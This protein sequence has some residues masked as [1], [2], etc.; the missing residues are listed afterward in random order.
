MLHS[1]YNNI[2]LEMVIRKRDI[3]D[4]TSCTKYREAM[5]VLRGLASLKNNIKDLVKSYEVLLPLRNNIKDLVKSYDVLLP[6]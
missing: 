6:L 5:S 3:E 1:S 4:V 2:K